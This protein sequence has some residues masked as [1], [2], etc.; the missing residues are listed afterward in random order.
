MSNCS[1]LRIAFLLGA[2]IAASFLLSSSPYAQE[3]FFP[4]IEDTLSPSEW[5]YVGPF[6][7]GAR[8]G[9]VGAIDH[10]ENLRPREG[11]RLPSILPQ[12]GMV[13]W[14]KTAPDSTGWVTLEYQD[15]WWDT[16][17]TI[18]GIAGIVDA[19]Y[20]YAEFE[21][22]GNKRALVIA[23][24]AGSFYL[25]GEKF[26]GD[27]YG[28]DYIKTPVLLK[29][30]TN[31]V[32]MEL[33]GYG[34]H[35][36][37]FKVIPAPSPIM[38]IA[39]DATV[40]DIVEGETQILSAGIAILNTTTKRLKEVK[41]S[42]GGEGRFKRTEKVVSSIIPF[43]VK[44]L[45]VT[46][47]LKESIT[48]ADTVSVPIEV[49]YGDYSS[50]DRLLLRVRKK[51][52]SRKVTFIS[53]IDGSCQY[54]S[55]LPP[56]DYDPQKEYALILGLHGAGVEASGLIDCHATKDWAF[57]ITATNRKPFGFDWQDWGRLDALEVLGLAKENYPIDDDRVYLTGHSMGGHGTWHIALAHPDL[58]AAAAP[59]AG[60]LCFQLYV[61]W[62]LQKSYIFAEPQQVGVRDQSLREDFALNFVE[63]ALN[64][65][66]FISHGANDDNVPTVHARMFV[67]LLDQLGYEYQYKEIPGKGHWYNLDD[68]SQTVCVDDP[69]VMEFLKSTRRN[70]FP[71]HIIFK[72]TNI[73]QNHK[74]YWAEIIQQEKPYFESRIEAQVKNG[75]IEIQTVNIAE[76]ALSLSEELLP[77]GTISFMVNGQKIDYKFTKN[78]KVYFHKK[79]DRFRIGK[80]KHPVMTKSSESYGPIKQ[81]YYSPF[82]LVYGTRGDSSTNEIT[83]HQARLEA[84]RWWSR[85]NGYAEILPDTEITP[86]M[87]ENFNLILFGG[88]EEN[89]VTAKLSDGLLI[90]IEKGKMFLGKKELRGDNL[91]A[92]FVYPNPL[93]PNKLIFVHQ[94]LGEEGLR[95][96]TSFTALYS[97]A[98]LPDFIIF[99]R[100]VKR[101]G[102]GGVVCAGFFD[103][104]WQLDDRYYYLKE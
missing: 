91:A 95:L 68:S 76:F 29:D 74:S 18:Y 47:E 59:F 42:V 99:D 85:G 2:F 100:K 89:L 97:G 75:V 93:N 34:D 51:E 16:L 58:F 62:F 71:K 52:Q 65:P 98:G 55:V 6:S 10:L 35:R 70:P 36:F 57:V 66:L 30:G 94:G 19:G 1:R 12:G 7:V 40:P 5:L 13:A 92:E 9:I 61:P 44:K 102:W 4:T 24:R 39:K 27:P 3:E 37:L 48:D 15:V 33:S 56:K 43:C 60:W 84:A 80:T 22:R 8:E 69:E 63:N 41:L 81:A 90:R 104:K 20:A 83:L 87:M 23:E 14:K 79:G 54:Y 32:M 64:L 96:S 73:G 26:Q 78:E 82:V 77:F 25:N 67:S 50:K 86:G 46:I 88:P 38:L 72:T 53:K 103:W 17:M 28:H 31:R 11:D 101:Q 21:N 49:S 45:P